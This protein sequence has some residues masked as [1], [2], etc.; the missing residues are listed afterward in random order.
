[1]R[2]AVWGSSGAAMREELRRW[3]WLGA[4]AVVLAAPVDAQVSPETIIVTGRSL[5]APAGAAAYGSVLL[6]RDT[7]TGDPSGR[8]ENVLRDVAGFQQFRRTDSRAANPTTQGATLRGLG[9]N[10]SSRALVLLDG[11]PVADPFAGYIAWSALDPERLGA[12]RVT[13]GGGAGPFGSGAVGGTIE[14]F[15]AGP[16]ELPRVHAGAA[17]GSRDSLEASAGTSG[18]LGAGFA[19]LSGRFDRGD[20]YIL[21]PERQRGPADLPAH[22]E[23]WS[24]QVRGLAPVGDATELQARA[25]LFNDQRLRGLAGSESTS[26]GADASLRLVGRGDLPFEALAYLQKR[27]FASGFASAN[28]ARTVAT[29]TLDQYNT[30]ATGAGAKIELRPDIGAAHELQA[31]VDLRLA[32]G[33]TRERFRFQ[34]GQFTRLRRA[35]GETRLAGAY[36]E[37]SWRAAEALTLTGGVRIDRWWIDDGRLIETDPATGG[38]TLT[39]RPADRAGWEP[40]ARAGLLYAATPALTL[41]AAGYLGWRLPTLNELYRPFRVGADATGANAALDP[42]RLRGVE[43]GIDYQ[44]LD[45]L[46]LGATLFW[47]EL[48]DAIGNVT[49][50]AGPGNFPGVGFVAAGGAFRQRQNLDA[51]RSRGVELWGR[52]TYA[53]WTASASYALTDARVRAGGIAAALDGLRPAQTPRH[54]ASATLGYASPLGPGASLTAR[55]VGRQF[56]DDLQSRRL[57]DALTVD[58]A[59]RLPLSDGL[60]V[61]LRAE[62]IFDV[63]VESGISGTGIVDRAMPRTLWAGLRFALR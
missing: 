7:L 25:L 18:R 6:D 28:A 10:A 58:A 59:A 55:Y 26:E 41:R 34:A 40:T 45:A 23:Q 31:G 30:P 46:N 13:R 4:A 54:Q 61:E 38:T 29:P 22:Y 32:S 17:Y 44:P 53:D 27:R 15:S 2:S 50:G 14:L 51:V 36:L 12:V 48:R 42:E 21:I 56:E 63:E 8:L 1:M 39:E 35:G 33:E 37:E 16:N 62:N 11:V 5:P 49:I 57:D 9:G 43:A 3:G 19:A 20:G 60:S 24:V 52:F 47:N